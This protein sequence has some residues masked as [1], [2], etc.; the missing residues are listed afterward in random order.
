MAIIT[1]AKAKA[2]PRGRASGLLC[3]RNTLYALFR[4]RN[5]H[6]RGP[7]A[8]ASEL[9][10]HLFH[11]LAVIGAV[12]RHVAEIG[13]RKLVLRQ[14]RTVVREGLRQRGTGGEGFAQT[15]VR[16]GELEIHLAR[17][18]EVLRPDKRRQRDLFKG[19]DALLK[20]VD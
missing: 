9:R 18:P 11:A 10:V 17:R 8:V 2:R 1:S 20:L 3:F 6:K 15:I 5:T 12:G 19:R 13:E 7:D 14:R 16:D 4:L